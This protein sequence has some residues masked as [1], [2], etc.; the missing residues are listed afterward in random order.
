MTDTVSKFKY[1]LYFKTLLL[2]GLESWMAL[3]TTWQ[4]RC[5]PRKKRTWLQGNH[6]ESKTTTK[7]SNADFRFYSCSWKKMDRHWNTTITWSEVSSKCQKPSPDCYDMINQSP[8]EATEQ[9]TTVTS[10][11]SAGRRISTMLRN[12]YLKIGYQL[13]QKEEVRRKGFNIAWI[14]CWTCVM[15]LHSGHITAWYS[16]HDSDILLCTQTSWAQVGSKRKQFSS[17]CTAHFAPVLCRLPHLHGSGAG[18]PG[19][20]IL[21]YSWYCGIGISSGDGICSRSRDAETSARGCEWTNGKSPQQS[22]NTAMNAAVSGLAG[23]VCGETAPRGYESRKARAVRT[24]Q[25]LWRLGF[26]IERIR[27]YARSCLSCLAEDSET[28]ANSADGDSTTRTAVCNIAVPPHDAHTELSTESCENSWKQRFRSLQTTVP[29]VRNVRSGRQHGII[30]AN[31]DLQVWFQDWRRGRPSEWI[32]ELV[33]RY[34]EANGTDPVPDQVKKRRALFR[35]RLS[36]WRHTSSVDCWKTG[37][38]QRITRVDWR[39]LE[40]QTHLQDDFSRKHT[41]DEDSMEVDAVSRK[42]KGKEKS[43]KGKKGGKKGKESHSGKS[44]GETTTEHSRFDLECRNCGKYGHKASDCWYKQ[45]NKSKGKGTGKSKSKV[46]E[47]SESDNSKQV[48]DWCPSSNTSAQQ[49]NLSQVNTIGCADEGLWIFSLEDSKKRRYSVNWDETNLTEKWKTEEHELMIDSGCFGHVC[50]LWFAPQFP[51]VSST[52]VDAVAATNVALQHY[53]QKVVYG[54][55]MTNSGKRILIQITFD[56]MNVRKPLLSTSALKHR[57]VTIIFNHDYDRIIFR[58]ETVNLIFHDSHSYLHVIL[59]NGIPPCKAL[60]MAGE[61]AT[62][63]VDEEVYDNDGN[64]RNEAREASSGDRR[65]IADADQAGQLDIPGEAKTARSPRTPEPPTGAARMAHNA[66]HVPFRDWCPICVASRGRSSP[67]RRVVVNKTAETLPKFQ[68]D[69]MFIRTVAE[70]K[71]QPRIT[72]VETRSGVVI[73]FMCARKGGYED[74]TM[75]ILRHFEAYGFLNPVIIQCDIKMSIIDVCRKVARERNARTVLR[76]APK[77]SH[78]S[79][80]FVEAVHGH[81]QGLARCYQTQIETNTGT[82]LSAISPAIPFAMRY[83]GF[84]PS[85]FT[86]RPDGRIPFQYLLGTPYVSPLCTFGE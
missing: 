30:R 76:F 36:L 43:G 70:S 17:L 62:N 83:A 54:H 67:Q 60:V 27:G 78:Q 71:T 56:V 10:S 37:K 16:R 81:I 69:Y 79:N 9:S 23:T 59:T 84:V 57:G 35:T 47:I 29:N 15:L 13:W 34:D 49:A 31:H 1:H 26:H 21:I 11:K 40:E 32:L 73:S 82:Q 25:R 63:D 39:L 65:T 52:N 77:T 14:A 4:N 85:R 44:Y 24:W 64:E 48:D 68:T 22:A 72:F 3:I 46:T 5:W 41:H 55:V 12:G 42:G 18:I 75:E 53:G 20:G 45:T 7:A 8:E 19:I 33:R 28:I 51:M 74:L 38:L 80:G 58:N 6:C 66:T 61:S 2:L 86:V 50:P